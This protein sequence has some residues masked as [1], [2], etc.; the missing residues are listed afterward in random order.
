[1]PTQ[2]WAQ[3]IGKRAKKES[4]AVLLFIVEYVT[5][6]T[7][8]TSRSW[9]VLLGQ[10]EGVVIDTVRRCVALAVDTS[11]HPIVVERWLCG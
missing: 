5:R 1:M 11:I 2:V 10:A 8:L 3:K 9:S 6:R 4:P 7:Q